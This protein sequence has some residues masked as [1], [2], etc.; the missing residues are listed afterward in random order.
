[1]QFADYHGHEFVLPEVLTCSDLVFFCLMILV[2]LVRSG[3]LDD[4]LN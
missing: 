4:R 3:L 1:M 2:R